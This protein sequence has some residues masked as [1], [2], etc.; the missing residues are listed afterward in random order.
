MPAPPKTSL[1]RYG[2][3]LAPGGL[4]F[5]QGLL[6]TEP[7]G[8]SYEDL[9]ADLPSAQAWLTEALIGWAHARELD[10]P[11]LELTDSDLPRLRRLRGEIRAMVEGGGG[12]GAAPTAQLDLVVAADARLEIRPRGR[13][14]SDWI[15]SATLGECLTA[16]LTD[17]FSRLKVCA[18]PDCRAAFFDRSRNR[19]GQW[20]DVKICGNRINLRASRARRRAATSP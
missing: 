19:S 4:A 10:A 15:A 2:A 5:V 18:N 3:A 6:N 14:A 7:A 20:H 16:Q 12:A 8:P 1:D 9:L 17:R 11:A 13:K